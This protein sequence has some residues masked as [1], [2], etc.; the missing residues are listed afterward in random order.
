MC[1][2]KLLLQ[3]REFLGV[4]L[5]PVAF[6]PPEQGEALDRSVVGATLTT[7]VRCSMLL[8][9]AEA[10]LSHEIHSTSLRS[11]LS[12]VCGARNPAPTRDE[13]MKTRVGL[14]EREPS[15]SGAGRRYALYEEKWRDKGSIHCEKI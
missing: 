15:P 9:P 4:R 6:G 10:F 2:M 8:P 5:S 7:S 1:E 3:D 11:S 12:N 13:F 14:S